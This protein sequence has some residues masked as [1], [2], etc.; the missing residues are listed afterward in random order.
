MS[1]KVER[2]GVIELERIIENYELLESNIYK[3]DKYPIWDGEIFVK[4]NPTEKKSDFAFRVPIQVKSTQNAVENKFVME[5]ADLEAYKEDG[6][7]V[8]FV[9]YLDKKYKFV[10]L[11]YRTLIPSELTEMLTD[12]VKQQRTKT[13][14]IFPLMEKNIY[15]MLCEFNMRKRTQYEVVKEKIPLITDLKENDILKFTIKKNSK[16]FITP[17]IEKNNGL[18]VPIE[19]GWQL[20]FIEDKIVVKI[21]DAIFINY[22]KKINGEE[23]ILELGKGFRFIFYKTNFKFK[24]TIPDKISEAIES[25]EIL[26][27][28]IET[29]CIYINDKK[30]KFDFSQQTDFNK[31]EIESN[32][33]NLKKIR[34]I[35]QRLDV[36]EE[37]IVSKFDEKAARNLNL[38]HDGILNEKLLR[39]GLKESTLVN[40]SV[41]NL[42]FIILYKKEA[43]KQGTIIDLFKEGVDVWS[44]GDGIEIHTSIF[45]RL[46]PHVW[47]TISRYDFEK[48][49]KS[50]D[51][52]LENYPNQDISS[53][54]TLIINLIFA[55]DI[56]PDENRKVLLEKW[57]RELFVYADSNLKYK[58]DGIY[59]LNKLQAKDR[60]NE[61]GKNDYEFLFNMLQKYNDNIEYVFAL[62][63]LLKS[64]PL[65]YLNWEKFSEDMK[66]IYRNYP[67][68]NLYKELK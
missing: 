41:A 15:E 32:I 44:K 28:F 67:I 27:E 47:N 53:I 31:K 52:I 48:I 17:Y 34:E 5:V 22:E 68:Y 29:E 1:G 51:F 65:A 30:Y 57:I 13:I 62:A 11:Y 36:K 46:E 49:V 26:K 23:V 66:E 43:D 58:E 12:K 59:I 64:K 9:V 63:T 2:L 4:K 7:C 18:K 24:Y 25:K 42:N 37:L 45:E 19:T 16:D 56:C 55:Y 3:R 33:S 10:D 50:Y 61:L 40:L 39:I 35:L 21:G 38:L 54:N 8:V 60:W 6:G 14:E 20:S